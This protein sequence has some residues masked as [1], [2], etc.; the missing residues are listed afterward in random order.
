MGKYTVA[1][2]RRE[3]EKALL[4]AGLPPSSP[5]LD[6]SAVARDELRKHW[7][8]HVRHRPP[9][10]RMAWLRAVDQLGFDDGQGERLQR[11]EKQ[12]KLL[13]SIAASPAW[14]DQWER[15]G[16][17]MP[18]HADA[19]AKRLGAKARAD[20][21]AEVVHANGHGMVLSRAGIRVGLDEVPTPRLTPAIAVELEDALDL[22]EYDE[23]LFYR[24]PEYGRPLTVADAG[25]MRL[26]ERKRRLKVRGPDPFACGWAAGAMDD[27]G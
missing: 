8:N 25:A 13:L 14:A 5:A 9:G 20:G 3:R 10:E 11:L 26:T 4:A 18:V 21:V 27:A 1:K 15:D 7:N 19:L 16:T 2:A 6:P 24:A 23:A 17:R 12:V 22:M